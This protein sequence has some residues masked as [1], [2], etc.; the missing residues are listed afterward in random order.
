MAAIYAGKIGLVDCQELAALASPETHVS[1]DDPP[2]LI[3]H[4]DQDRNVPLR[5]SKLLYDA[6]KEAG[7]DATFVTI[8][9]AGHGFGQTPGIMGT[10]EE[11][12]GKHL[13]G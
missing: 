7:V 4:G 10:V 8:P 9:G 1:A 12:F 6:L 2:F 13:K 3:M 5:Q 11:F